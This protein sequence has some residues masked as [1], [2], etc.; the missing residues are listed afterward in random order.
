[1]G[2]GAVS[3]VAQDSGLTQL[4]AGMLGLDVTDLDP[5]AH[6]TDDL[7]LDSI[8]RLELT[9]W[10][11]GRGV[12][13]DGLGA[14]E[15]GTVADARELLAS[16][17]VA[18]E[19]AGRRRPVR[20]GA[21]GRDQ[22]RPARLRDGR[23]VLRPVTAEYT[24]FLYEL[25]ISEEVGF[26]W[27]FRGAVPTQETFA[28]GLNQGVLAQFVVTIPATGEPVGLVV[29]YNA[30]MSRGVAHL[31]AVFVPAYVLSGLGVGAVD[32][33]VRHLFQVW[34]LRKLYMEMPE[35]NFELIASGAGERFDVEGRLRDHN[36]YDGRFWDEYV[37][38]VYRH[39]VGAAPAG[40]SESPGPAR[41]TRARTTA[42]Q[43]VL[44]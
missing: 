27:R 35:Y 40:G 32:L 15:P 16:A 20:G 6:L 12:D 30:D 31:A 42:V 10:L 23:F 26:R 18:A 29:A 9:A 22:P 11:A 28:A 8:Q 25:A 37:L 41:P 3:I 44:P 39:H 38:A 33:F 4:L 13:V 5:D 2:I 43:Q 21:P 24:Q 17:G 19:P 36:Y 7:R 34:N 14:G 1:M